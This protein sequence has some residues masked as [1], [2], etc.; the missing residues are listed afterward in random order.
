MRINVKS[1]GMS[2]KKEKKKRERKTLYLYKT[3]YRI[4]ST[5]AEESAC[6]RK[7]KISDCKLAVKT[8]PTPPTPEIKSHTPMR[9]F[10]F[11]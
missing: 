8:K 3:M 5:G 10:R 1:P 2:T 6:S 4:I 11:E 9:S 7:C